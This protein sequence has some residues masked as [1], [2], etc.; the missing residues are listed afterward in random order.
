M[1][2]IIQI[3]CLNEA[4][5]LDV[6]LRDLPK[7]IPGIDQ[8]ETLVIDDGSTDNTSETA[9]KLGVRHIVRH[10]INRG[11]AAAFQTGL[12][13]ALDEGAD[14]VVNTDADNQYNGADIAKL[15]EPIIKGHADMVVGIRPI[16]EISHFSW[17]KKRLQ[18]LGSW[19]V[20]VLSGTDVRDA[21]SGFRAYTRDCA[22]SIHLIT[23]FSHTLETLI[24]MG[25][26]NF[27]VDQV[28]VRVNEKLRESRLFRSMREYITRSFFDIFR[29]YLFYKG[30]KVFAI[31][32]T[33]LF[34]PGFALGLRFLHI[35][36]FLGEGGRVQSLILAT[37]LMI[38]GFQCFLVAILF[39]AQIGNRRLME[40]ALSR[41]NK[42]P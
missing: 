41:M 20:R 35:H 9:K 38:T 2:L 28:D 25:N 14:I 19:V 31:S 30:D 1:K 29:I 13:K 7:S 33:C 3:P 36:F 10:S 39:A 16:G 26:K 27:V 37:L 42:A 4:K 11:L 17:L 18:R 6:T 32:G 15:V 8:I 23:R 21:T 5:T 22:A 40:I 34:L 24:Q 12:R